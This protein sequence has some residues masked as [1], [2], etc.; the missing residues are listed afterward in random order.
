MKKIKCKECKKNILKKEELNLVFSNYNIFPLHNKCYS[1]SIQ[2]YKRKNINTFS[3]NKNKILE[4][5]IIIFNIL[6]SIL[7]IFSIYNNNLEPLTFIIIFFI[8]NSYYFILRSFSYI[9]FERFLN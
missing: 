3:L 6:F 1:K 8:V 7:S 9:I 5:F 4:S 2:K